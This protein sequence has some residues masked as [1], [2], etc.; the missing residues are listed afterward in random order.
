MNPVSEDPGTVQPPLDN[1][2]RGE[3]RSELE[4]VEWQETS[5]SDL[6]YGFPHGMSG[7]LV[8]ALALAVSQFKRASTELRVWGGASAVM[9]AESFEDRVRRHGSWFPG[10]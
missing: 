8:I 3:L 10:D 7:D 4:A 5:R 9:P 6:R 1:R 2:R